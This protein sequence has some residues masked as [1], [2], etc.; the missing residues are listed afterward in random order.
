MK[1]LLLGHNAASVG[2]NFMRAFSLGRVLFRHGHHVTLIAARRKAGWRSSETVRDGVKIV[3]AADVLPWRIRHGG[4][5]PF[6]IVGRIA[7]MRSAEF[8]IVHAFDQRPAVSLPAF[9]SARARGIPLISD[10]ADLWGLDGIGSTRP[11]WEL[12]LAY[13][14]H[15]TERIM[16]KRVWAGTYASSYLKQRWLNLRLSRPQLAWLPAGANTDLIVPE[17]RTRARLSL[18]LSTSAR[19]VV[20]IGF[21]KY[22]RTLMSESLILWAAKNPRNL[23]VVS[24]GAQRGLERA[25]QRRRLEA[26]LVNLGFVDYG[27]LSVVL[28]AADVL[29]LPYR[30]SPINLG[31][32]PN[33]LGDYLASGRP[34]VSN[35]TGDVGEIIRDN[36]LGLLPREDPEDIADAFD[37]LI[38]APAQARLMGEAGR[39]FAEE[40]LSWEK[41]AEQMETF[42]RQ[43]ITS[44]ADQIA[45]HLPYEPGPTAD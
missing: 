40:K 4:L 15:F 6:D 13:F 39:R 19:V 2:G 28:A 14:D 30:R 18:G 42:Y 7:W 21:A 31:R 9:W 5:S 17:S 37:N 41:L 38:E 8:D 34:I 12:P 10:W 35:P 32:F 27:R 36:N 22:D 25:F 11:A 29:F 20:H 45:V 3:Q 16:R 43:I 24:G 33:K 1:I 23:C 44:R 26:Q